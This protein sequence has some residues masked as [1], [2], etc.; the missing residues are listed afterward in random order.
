MLQIELEEEEVHLLP[1]KALWWPGQQTLIVADLHW[2]KTAH[3][4]K[5]GIAVPI[6][7][8]N[9]DEARLTSLINKY[10]AERLVIAGDMFHSK[11]NKEVDKFDQWRKKHTEVEMHLVLGNHDILPELKYTANNIELHHNTM[12][13]GPFLVSHDKIPDADKFH[14]HGH[15]HP[16]VSLESIGR[17]RNPRVPCFAASHE[18]LVLPSFGRFTGSHKLSLADYKN[19]Y[20]IADEEVIQW[21]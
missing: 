10:M 19:V 16:C 9:S 12:D 17:N 4:R 8:Q 3:F 2:G 15:L 13:T 7:T 20:V 21:K 1:E 18:C 11:Q 6:H 14:L 5:H